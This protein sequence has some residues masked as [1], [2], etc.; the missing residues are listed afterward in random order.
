MKSAVVSIKLLFFFLF[1]L[2]LNAVPAFAQRVHFCDLSN[3][4]NLSFCDW[5]TAQPGSAYWFDAGSKFY[6]D[7]IVNGNTYQFLATDYIQAVGA[8]GKLLVREDTAQGKVFFRLL[9]SADTQE[10]L[11]Y[12]YNLKV[13]DTLKIDYLSNH[14]RYEILDL[15]TVQM[16]GE[17]YKRWEIA[18]PHSGI[19]TYI[20][21]GIGTTWGPEFVVFP[22]NFE[23][24]YQL[25]CFTSRG[26]QRRCMPPSVLF[27]TWILSP[28]P[29][30]QPIPFDS[31]DNDASCIVH[32][33]ETS[34]VSGPHS[35]TKPEVVPNPGGAGAML[36]IPQMFDFYHLTVRDVTGRVV[37]NVQSG[38]S[39]Q[40][41]IGELVQ[42]P[43]LYFY[44][45]EGKD[46]RR[47][48]G[49]FVIR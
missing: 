5:S 4:W 33:Y 36:F 14:Y 16:S 21:E 23:S 38:S 13:G 45:V 27:T 11:M 29:K 24:A 39:R 25:R 47:F 40:Q 10:H 19:P 37:A 15:G 8:S 1:I 41:P 31:F 12:D 20:I 22:N 49:R 48:A 43:G 2:L 9:L 18:N 32:Y 6:G 35:E 42:G 30:P 26:V 7:T 34:G 46:G 17:S 44:S 28:Y 3:K